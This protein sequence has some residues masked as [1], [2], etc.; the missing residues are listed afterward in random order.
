[1]LRIAVSYTSTLAPSHAPALDVA[2]VAMYG[3]PAVESK[4]LNDQLGTVRVMASGCRLQQWSYLLSIPYIVRVWRLSCKR[5]AG[6]MSLVRECEVNG[7]RWFLVSLSL[8]SD[9][10]SEAATAFVVR[11]SLQVVR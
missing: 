1:M 8:P 3:L 4:S 7:P 5:L 11:A 10:S 6:T 2:C 9:V